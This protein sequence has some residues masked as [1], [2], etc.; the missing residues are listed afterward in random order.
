[1]HTITEQATLVNLATRKDVLNG[2]FTAIWCTANETMFSLK[3]P[4]VCVYSST[5]SLSC[6]LQDLKKKK[7]KQKGLKW[8]D[9]LLMLQNEAEVLAALW[10][11]WTGCAQVL[12]S[13]CQPR[14]VPHRGS[15]LPVSSWDTRNTHLLFCKHSK[16]SLST[17]K[18]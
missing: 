8:G 11:A 1:M 17:R 9:Q 13:D 15:C 14:P 18:I 3:F 7:Q 12:W 5:Q 16:F 4:L 2:H 6:C 10:A